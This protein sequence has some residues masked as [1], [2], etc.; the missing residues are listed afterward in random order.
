[1][2]RL[3]LVGLLLA[4][5]ARAACA[6]DLVEIEAADR[7]VAFSVEIADTPATRA[8]GLMFR[9]DLALDAGMLF[10]WP[11]AAPRVFWMENTPLSLDMLFI[12]PEGR[13]CGLVERAE[14]FTRDPRPSGCDAMAVLE[15]HGGLAASL[16][17]GVGARLRHPAFGDGAAW[18]CR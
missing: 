16:G 2:M 5:A 4:G 10:L 3:S 9:D 1:M 14:P 15:I 18:P 6:P 8:Q 7:V 11:D 13:V 17:V 12:D